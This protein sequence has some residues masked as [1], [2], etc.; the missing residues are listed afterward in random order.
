MSAH[1]IIPLEP[2]VSGLIFDCD[3]TL[4]DSMPRHRQAWVETLEAHGAGFPEDLFYRLGGVSAPRIVE[5]LNDLYGLAMDPLAV[6]AEKEERAWELL[7]DVEPIAIVVDT[8]RAYRGR[9][10]LSVASGGTRANVNET[11][12]T[13]QIVDWFDAVVT[14]EDVVHPKPAPD[15]FLEAAYRMGVPPER[16]QVFEDSE[17]GLEAAQRAGMIGTDIRKWL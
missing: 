7:R 10:K 2:G 8:A 14:H 16:C 17:I 1:T 13:L 6:A 12:R 9:L 15:T 3:G 4:A 5:M 11:L